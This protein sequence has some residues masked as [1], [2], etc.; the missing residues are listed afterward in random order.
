MASSSDVFR[1]SSKIFILVVS[2]VDDIADPLRN[3]DIGT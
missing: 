3:D 1:A 2:K